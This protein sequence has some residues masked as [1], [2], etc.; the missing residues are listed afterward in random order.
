MYG[1]SLDAFVDNRSFQGG[2][3]DKGQAAAINEGLAH[4]QEQIKVHF[5][6]RE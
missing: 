2:V 4:L 6:E 3:I 1:L 5:S